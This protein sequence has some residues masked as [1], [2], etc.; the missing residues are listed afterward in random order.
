M[1]NPKRPAAT[2]S[3]D[4]THYN[5]EDF[6]SSF[7]K[8]IILLKQP[9]LA[10]PFLLFILVI[11]TWISVQFHHTSSVVHTTTR[12][13]YFTKILSSDDVNLVRFS[14]VKFPSKIFKDPQGWIFDPLTITLEAGISGGAQSCVSS[15]LGE[16]RPGGVRGNHRHDTCNETFVVWGADTFFKLQVGPR[17]YSEMFISADEVVVAASSVGTAHALINVDSSGRRTFFLG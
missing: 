10:F 8:L 7:S 17:S 12:H 1:A 4:Q 11:L 15:H 14:T 3:L 5:R 2:N 16:I 13:S 9:V 6:I